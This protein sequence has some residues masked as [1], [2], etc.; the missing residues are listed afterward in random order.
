MCI[1][2]NKI[3]ELVICES[4]AITLGV[5]PNLMGGGGMTKYNQI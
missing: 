2:P 3:N 4:K 1:D 5:Y